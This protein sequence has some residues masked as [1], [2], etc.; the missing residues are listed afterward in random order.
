[1]RRR[2]ISRK[3]RQ[4]A[5]AEKILHR[6]LGL[7]RGVD[8]AFFQALQKVIR[9]KVDQ[10]HLIGLFQHRVGQG[11]P[12]DDA[13]DLGHDVVEAF[14]MLNV[15][16]GVNVD[17]AVQQFHHVL[18]ALGVAGPLHVGVGQFVHQDEP[19]FP[20]KGCVQIK[21]PQLGAVVIDRDGGKDFQP[22]QKGGGF[23]AAVGFHDTDDRVDP[24]GLL[25]PGRFQHGVG[26]P[27]AGG[28]AEKDLQF[29]PGA[30][31]LL[32]LDPV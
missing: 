16:G 6:P 3:R 28:G 12:H 18:P 27:H 20:Q 5:L 4:V 1:M 17:A 21:F 24:F 15:E 8:L 23:L 9:G 10:L 30:L 26:F 11:F 32:R 29:A 13:G 14:Q 2:A 31:L 7:L 22:F 25:S 19:G